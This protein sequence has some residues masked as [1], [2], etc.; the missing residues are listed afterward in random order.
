MAEINSNNPTWEPRLILKDVRTVRMAGG[1]P[2]VEAIAAAEI[3]A[4]KRDDVDCVAARLE[5]RKEFA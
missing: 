2:H 1:M 3:A 5:R 4:E